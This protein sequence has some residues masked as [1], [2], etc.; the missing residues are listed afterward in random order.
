MKF[1]NK[2]FTA[3]GL[4]VLAIC[5]MTPMVSATDPAPISFSGVGQEASQKFT[6]D[7]GLSI[8]AMKHSGSSNFI[9]WLLDSNG[10]NV[11]LL[12]NVVGDFDGSKAV[13]ISKPGDYI[14]NIDADGPWTVDISQPRPQTA[15][16][17]PISFSGKGQQVSQFITLNPGLT[18]FE[19]THDGESN[20]IVWL[21]DSN[22][23]NVDLLVNEVGAFDGSKATG[24]KYSGIY[25]LN[26]AADG[27]WKIDVS[28]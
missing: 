27:N 24:I 16:S 13:G 25:C 11:D 4:L 20:F 12:A 14:L 6:L 5:I 7:E 9:V 8:F 15:Q 17:V 18:R 21:L 1:A 22:G 26:I 19:M 23:N 10:N 2:L 28:Q 3:F